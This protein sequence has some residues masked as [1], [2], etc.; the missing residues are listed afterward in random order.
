MRRGWIITA[1]I[2]IVIGITGL[3]FTKFNLGNEKLI[4]IEKKWTFDAQTLNNIT[5][6]GAHNH[7][8]VKFEKSDSDTGSI[9]VSGN[10]DQATIDQ[11]NKASIINNQYELDLTTAFKLQFFSFNFESSKIHITVALPNDDVI[12][13]V[14]IATNSGNFNIDDV[15]AKHAT[16]K[17]KSGNVNVVNVLAEQATITTNSGNLKAEDIQA[18]T[19]LLTTKSGNVNANNLTGDLQA[20]V[21]SGNIRIDKVSGQVTAESKSGN[22]TMSQATAHGANISASSGNVTFTVA[23]GF[24]GF[25]ELRSNSGNI[26][27]PDSI[28]TS[29]EIIKINTKSGNIK[30]K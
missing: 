23:E 6:I 7:L 2:L 12:D 27:A 29:S 10:T 20:T 3:S 17:T 16:F 30:V 4:N 22:I 18:D 25:Y 26:K 13:T 28:G 8:D 1:I 19:V 9:V 5:V 15:L 14:D 24:S 11:I 21:N